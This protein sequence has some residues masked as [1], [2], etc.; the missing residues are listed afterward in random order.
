MTRD[1]IIEHMAHAM[2]VY[3][4]SAGEKT[5]RELATAAYYAYMNCQYGEAL[6]APE[7]L[8]VSRNV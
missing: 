6:Q 5:W 1:R 4:E 2:M 8:N 3:D 7:L